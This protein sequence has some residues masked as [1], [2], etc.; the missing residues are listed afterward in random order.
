MLFLIL[1]QISFTNEIL[2]LLVR[3]LKIIHD[4][5]DLIKFMRFVR[6]LLFIELYVGLK[7]LLGFY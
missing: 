7:M 5:N 3:K 1:Y 4:F 6:K 2:V